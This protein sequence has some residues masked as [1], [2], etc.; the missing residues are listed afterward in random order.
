MLELLTVPFKSMESRL[1]R[2][3]ESKRAQKELGRDIFSLRILACSQTQKIKAT[4]LN[5]KKQLFTSIL[6][7]NY[8]KYNVMLLGR[9]K[10]K[11]SI[12]VMIDKIH[13]ESSPGL[14]C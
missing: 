9:N 12:N 7:G 8:E 13:I 3:R 1:C 6:K 2:T 11:P 14:K 4:G 5:L 10:E